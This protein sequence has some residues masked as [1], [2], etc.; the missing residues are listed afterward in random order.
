VRYDRSHRVAK[1]TWKIGDRVLLV[2]SRV[3]SGASRVV[4]KGRFDGVYIVT[5]IIAG[6]SDVGQAY[7]L[8]DET[9]GKTLRN[10]VSND[11]MKRYNVD[12]QQFNARLPRLE[13]GNGT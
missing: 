12:R 3:R 4:S 8:T 1:P 2:S 13:S 11:R 9:T 10:L 6:R 7:Q 5:G